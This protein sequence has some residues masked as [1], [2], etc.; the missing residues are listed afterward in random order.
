MKY[1]IKEFEKAGNDTKDMATITIGGNDAGFSTI[2]KNCLY[3]AWFPKDCRET[4][5]W[6]MEQT[7]GVRK[8][9]FRAFDEILEA[10]QRS[11]GPPHFTL[12]VTGKNSDSFQGESRELN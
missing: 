9:L 5:N 4:L 11:R 10:A 7:L 6:A 8:R 1:Q 3:R 12:F 2:L